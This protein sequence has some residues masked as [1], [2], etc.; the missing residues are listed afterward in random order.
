MVELPPLVERIG[1]TSGFGSLDYSF[2]LSGVC[3]ECAP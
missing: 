3:P 1:G 2:E